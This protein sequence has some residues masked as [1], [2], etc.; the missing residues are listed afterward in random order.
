MSFSSPSPPAAPDPAATSAAQ[1]VSNKETAAYT[2]GLNNINQNTPLGSIN[3]DY[4]T[5]DINGV[6]TPK[7][8]STVT[9]N[10]QSQDILNQTLT[11]SQ[12]LAKLGN[13]YMA[14]ANDTL[15]KPYD[16]SSVGAAPTANASDQQK[17]MANMLALEQ[18]YLDREHQSTDA[19]LANQ[20]ITQGS[21]AY[22]N[23]MMDQSNADNNLIQQNV[24]NSTAQEQSQFDMANS[25]YQTLLNNYTAQYNQPLNEVNALRSGSQVSM[26][27]FNAAPTTPVAGTNVSGNINSAYQNALAGYNAQVGQNNST[28]GGLFSLGGSG[29][30]AYGTYAGLTASDIRLKKNIVKIGHTPSGIPVY[31]FE[32][33]SGGGK[34]TGVMAQDVEKSIPEAVVIMTNG[35]KA[36]NYSMV[37]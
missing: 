27:S 9:L 23:A 28:M 7:T 5:Q 17:A 25:A 6:T 1:T 16:L 24:Q 14:N 8:S 29:L 31:E 4:G 22:R 15:S 21:E 30:G 34:Q 32:Y 13:S 33:K 35:Y 12:N 11:G 36:V 18:P 19:K 26:P 2:A 10:P 3:Y 37:R 20:G